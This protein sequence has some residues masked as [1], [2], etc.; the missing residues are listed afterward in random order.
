MLGNA[1]EGAMDRIRILEESLWSKVPDEVMQKLK[2]SLDRALS[3]DVFRAS[4]DKVGFTPLRPKSLP[5]IDQFVA[6]DGA[7][8]ARVIK[9]LNISLD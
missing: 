7:R 9:A 4:L 8:W 3:D 2:A 1:Q 5:E 6:A